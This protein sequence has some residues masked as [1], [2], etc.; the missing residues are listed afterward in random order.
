MEISIKNL[1]FYALVGFFLFAGLYHFI[2]PEFYYPLIPYFFKYKVFINSASGILEI[3]LAL[4]LLSNK[5]RKLAAYGLIL[6]LVFFIPSHVYFIQIGS[7][8]DDGL[9]VPGWVGWIRL[10]LIHP[11]LIYWIFSNRK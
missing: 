9:C 8:I 11:L 5:Y 2:N 4:G 3:G 10:L 6:L 7:C 1:S